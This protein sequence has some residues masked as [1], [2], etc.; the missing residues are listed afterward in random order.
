MID[1]R[2]FI[3]FF[4]TFF[5]VLLG[6]FV[7]WKLLY[8]QDQIESLQSPIEQAETPSCV[9]EEI[10][11]ILPLQSFFNRGSNSA[12]LSMV[13]KVFVTQWFYFNQQDLLKLMMYAQGATTFPELKQ[14]FEI[15]MQ[16]DPKNSAISFVRGS[17]KTIEKNPKLIEHV[18]VSLKQGL[19]S[20]LHQLRGRMMEVDAQS[21]QYRKLKKEYRKALDV[22]ID[23]KHGGLLDEL[24][25]Q[26]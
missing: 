16:K 8:I 14:A 2:F 11:L 5:T 26:I 3:M 18:N 10:D 25:T 7:V 1:R 21:R 22:W 15:G 20:E 17:L 13:K 4:I 6:G 23:E 19:S 9:Y 24:V 12:N